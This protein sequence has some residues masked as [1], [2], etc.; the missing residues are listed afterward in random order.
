MIGAVVGGGIGVGVAGATAGGAAVYTNVKEKKEL[1][2]CKSCYYNIIIIGSS[3][4]P[5]YL[6]M[7]LFQCSLQAAN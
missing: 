4:I 2:E 6:Y 1:E 7:L 5:L 3:F